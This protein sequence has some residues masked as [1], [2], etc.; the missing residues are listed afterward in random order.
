MT[1]VIADD[2]DDDKEGDEDEAD[3]DDDDDD[4]MFTTNDSCTVFYGCFWTRLFEV[5]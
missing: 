3:A 2:E 4:P 1:C 5:I